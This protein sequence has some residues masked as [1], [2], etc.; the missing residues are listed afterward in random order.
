MDITIPRAA[1]EFSLPSFYCKELKK[2]IFCHLSH[3]SVNLLTW[4]YY[5]DFVSEA[6]Q[7]LH[8]RLRIL[9]RY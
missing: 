9:A 5:I 2:N 3:M 8:T 6:P 4:D 1:E 7:Y